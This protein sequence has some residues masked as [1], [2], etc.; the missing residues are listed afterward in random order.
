VAGA[1][2]LDDP[3]DS[4]GNLRAG[5]VVELRV[6]DAGALLPMLEKLDTQLLSQHLRGVPIG[7][8]MRDAGT[9]V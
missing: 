1:V 2:K 6:R 8:L 7:K 3:D 4:P 9:S 5:E